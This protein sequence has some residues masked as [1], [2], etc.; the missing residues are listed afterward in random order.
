MHLLTALY[1]P[2][3][4]AVASHLLLFTT[5]HRCPTDYN[6]QLQSEVPAST[7]NWPVWGPYGVKS[8]LNST[9]S[10]LTVLDAPADKLNNMFPYS[11]CE[12]PHALR[13]ISISVEVWGSGH[14]PC[15]QAFAMI[16]VLSLHHQQNPFPRVACIFTSK[17]V[18][19]L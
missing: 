2:R 7:S 13:T 9:L 4:N 18:T 1:F 5:I 10:F 12:H 19:P 15:F 11:L 17:L 3:L 8:V 6:H 14:S 16:P